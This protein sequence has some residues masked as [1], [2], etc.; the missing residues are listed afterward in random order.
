M[1]RE[2]Q[3]PYL[4]GNYAPVSDQ[5]STEHLKVKGQIPSDLNGLLLRNGPNPMQAPNPKKHH[6]FMGDG[7]L[8]G[9]RISEGRPIWYRNQTVSANKSSPNTHVIGHAGNIY[10]LVEAGGAPVM[11]DP[12]L[13]SLAQ[14]P[15][16]GT[17]K[18]GFTA[19]T[20]HEAETGSL[21]AICYDFKRGYRASYLEIDTDNRVKQH[22]ELDLPGQPMI[23]DCAITDQ[24]VIVFDLPVTFSLSRM[25]RRYLPFAWNPKHQAR[26]G[27]L[28]RHQPDQA[29]VWFEIAPCYIFHPQ[30]AFE[31]ERGQ[32]IL[33]GMRYERIF[34]KVKI[35]PFGESL[36]Y[37]TRWTLDPKTGD[38]TEQQ[39]DDRPAEF[40]RVHPDMEGKLTQYGYALGLARDPA[41]TNFNQII[42]YHRHDDRAERHTLAPSQMAGEPIFVPSAEAT[43]EDD[44]YLLSFVF[45][46]S[47]ESSRVIILDAK[48]V[49]AEP[50]G[51]IELPQ[52]V[53]FGFHGSWISNSP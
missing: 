13:N 26:I 47:T 23:H 4:E 24:Y 17:L 33:E 45:D 27:L 30:N 36:P 52:R 35:G 12:E 15:F 18:R 37:L 48:D 6:W 34:D 42:K 28:N 50:I 20:K 19:H 7:M 8:H 10:A 9:L 14:A 43:L 1:F 32:V 3:N 2:R 51:E 5:L 53:P 16:D 38:T 39:I 44:G 40:P 22:H 29:I 21:H 31:D 49:E 41:D 11:V 25:I 46:Q